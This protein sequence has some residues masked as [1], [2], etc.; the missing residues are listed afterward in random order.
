MSESEDQTE[1]N[2]KSPLG[3]IWIILVLLVAVLGFA[4]YNNLSKLDDAQS[5]KAT[6]I[7]GKDHG[8][9]GHVH[10]M[11]DDMAATKTMKPALN[12]D[13]VVNA[14]FDLEKASKPR[15]LGNP[16]AP[17]KI[18]EH[19]SFTCGHCS[20]FHQTNFKRIKADYVDTGKAYIIYNDFPL[21]GHDIK[22]GAAAR[23]VPEESYFTFI[24]LLFETQKDWLKEDYIAYIKQNALLTGASSAQIEACLNSEELFEALAKQREVAMDKHDV[25]ATPTLVINDSI[26]IPGLS[27]Y[28]D[29]KKALDAELEKSS[30]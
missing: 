26:V 17:I 30:K 4:I 24:Q 25:K 14:D 29:L 7:A 21:N 19:S 12:S 22:I 23:C 16:D 2:E 11:A 18:S 28:A 3:I 5:S 9:A 20:K 27:P 8:E 10:D 6:E 1:K 15:I 13:A